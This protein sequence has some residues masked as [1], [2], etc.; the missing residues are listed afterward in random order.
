MQELTND[1]LRRYSRHLM[2][3]EISVDGQ[4]KLKC[5]KVIIIGAGGL[6][7][8]AATYLVAAGVSTI[9]IADFDVV[10]LTNTQRQ[11]L[12]STNDIGKTK[13]GCRMDCS[14]P[15]RYEQFT[16]VLELIVL[17]RIIF[18]IFARY[19]AIAKLSLCRTV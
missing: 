18:W 3:P 12:Y 19:M 2:I 6:G 8:A 4:N 16:C 7:S 1:E 11:I 5:A 13:T 15:H 10:D 17:K 14:H 9:G